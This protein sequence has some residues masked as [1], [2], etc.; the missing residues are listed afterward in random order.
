MLTIADKEMPNRFYQ[1]TGIRKGLPDRVALLV[2]RTYMV[3]DFGG[4]NG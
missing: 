3:V 1:Q 4:G 2:S